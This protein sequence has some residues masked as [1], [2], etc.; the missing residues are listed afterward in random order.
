MNLT[1]LQIELRNM[2]EQLSVLHNE[3]ENMKPK[4]EDVQKEEFATIDKL[5]AQFPI[6]NS[7]ITNMSDI[8]KK[9]L[10]T[11]LAYI[12][13]ATEENI[14]AGMLYLTR[15]SQGCS[16]E[17]KTADIYKLG[18]EVE[19]IFKV[20]NEIKDY[21]DTVLVEAFIISNLRG[22]ADK[23][24]ISAIA[25]VASIMGCDSEELQMIAQI[26]KYKLVEDLSI[27][28]SLPIPRNSRWMGRFWDFIP[29]EWIKNN[30]IKCG[31]L[32]TKKYIDGAEP[33]IG[34]TGG[35]LSAAIAIQNQRNKS[36][37]NTIETQQCIIENLNMGTIVREG[38][39]ICE[40][41]EGKKYDYDKKKYIR[42]KRND[43]AL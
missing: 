8:C 1:E 3:I 31:E 43:S 7:V 36:S 32:C 14:Y 21:K 29:Y 37:D 38:D 5:A 40:F 16:A 30:R 27:L 41:K 33:H 11:C 34:I 20:V 17:L 13:L 15:L 9:M 28:Q 23:K 2:E 25:D 22:P 35:F 6:S 12:V 10:F 18:I 4:S 39:V 26:A 19:D 42:K 24:C